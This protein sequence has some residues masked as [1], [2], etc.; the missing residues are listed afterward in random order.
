MSED[1]FYSGESEQD[2]YTEEPVE[3]QGEY[4]QNNTYY[5]ENT[6]QYQQ[7][8]YQQG[9]QQPYQEPYQEPYQPA[10]QAFGIASMIIG[11][12]SLVLFCSCINIPLA[13]VAII[14]GIIQLVK[15]DSSK[16][17]AIAGIITSAVSI[18]LFIIMVVA[19]CA[20][21]DFKEQFEDGMLKGIEEYQYNYQIPDI[22]D[23]DDTF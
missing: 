1:N 18:I 10:S 23:D 11:I 17:A 19:F 16:G 4:Q 2:V 21:T 6:Y 8:A 5:Q 20:S 3:N 13:V 12:I 9:Y 14:F 15:K 22:E 7:G